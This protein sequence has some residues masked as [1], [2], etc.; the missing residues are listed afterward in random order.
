[1][2]FDKVGEDENYEWDILHTFGEFE[3]TN[4]KEETLTLMH[5]LPEEQ[6]KGT[7]YHTECEYCVDLR[8]FLLNVQPVAHDHHDNVKEKDKDKDE[9][10]DKEEQIAWEEM[11][12]KLE[13]LEE[14]LAEEKQW[15]QLEQAKWLREKDEL[16]KENDQ[17]RKELTEERKR[18]KEDTE[19]ARRRNMEE[20]QQELLPHSHMRDD[21]SLLAVMKVS[22]FFSVLMT[23]L[24]CLGLLKNVLRSRNGQTKILIAFITI[25]MSY[26][27]F[28]TLH[29]V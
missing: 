6:Q 13:H 23:T 11:G 12:M 20:E 2:A 22:A 29:L 26:F 21:W 24:Y 17:L 15:K 1:M 14:K 3:I 4:Y 16:S 18:Q 5:E 25:Q 8:T 9:N 10:K 19:Q 7:V 27:T 28:S